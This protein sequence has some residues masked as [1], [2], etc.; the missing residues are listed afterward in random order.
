MTVTL[1]GTRKDPDRLDLIMIP[2]L[3][4]FNVLIF[5]TIITYLSICF[6]LLV[7]SALWNNNIIGNTIHMIFMFLSICIYKVVHVINHCIA[8]EHAAL[9][10][11]VLRKRLDCKYCSFLHILT[12]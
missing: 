7:V 11:C 3:D 2:P 12:L 4:I 5:M 9:A 1:L 10:W 6:Y 8:L